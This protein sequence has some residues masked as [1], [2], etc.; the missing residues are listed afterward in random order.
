MKSHSTLTAGAKFAGEANRWAG[1]LKPQSL[2]QR[3][4]SS[5]SFTS[6]RF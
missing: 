4:S 6:S 5:R 2:D 1:F 3:R